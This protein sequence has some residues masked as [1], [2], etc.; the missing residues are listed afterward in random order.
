M[1]FRRLKTP[2]SHH[3]NYYIPLHIL[4]PQMLKALMPVAVYVLGVAF[5]KDGF[6]CATFSNMV[7]ISI[8]VAVAAYGEAN[9]NLTGVSLQLGAVLFEATRLVLI[10]VGGEIGFTRRVFI[11]RSLR[12][13]VRPSQVHGSHAHYCLESGGHGKVFAGVARILCASAG[14]TVCSETA[15]W[16]CNAMEILHFSG[17]SH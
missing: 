15:C 9:F 17:A 6:R 10:Q 14:K 3:L 5:G 7:L 8:G 2:S 4:D 12:G 16:A 1:L 11:T 13:V